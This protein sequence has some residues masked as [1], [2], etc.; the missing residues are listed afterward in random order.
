M[1]TLLNASAARKQKAERG[2]GDA[3]VHIHTNSLAG[4]TISIPSYEE[5]EAIA[6]ILSD[7]DAEI[8]ALERKL[9][10]LR[11]VKRGMVQPVSYTHLQH[12]RLHYHR[13]QIRRRSTEGHF[14]D[15]C[16]P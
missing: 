2:Q 3:I 5:Q 7:M 10:K 4:I 14:H 6:K 11:Q 1:G 13:G 8:V 16:Q 15:R 12:P 9:A